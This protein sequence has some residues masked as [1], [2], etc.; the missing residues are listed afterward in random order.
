MPDLCMEALRQWCAEEAGVVSDQL[1]IQLNVFSRWMA[2]ALDPATAPATIAR[3]VHGLISRHP[4]L[5]GRRQLLADL[6]TNKSAGARDDGAAFG[7]LRYEEHGGHGH[8]DSIASMVGWLIGRNPTRTSAE[9]L[10]DNLARF[11]GRT[12]LDQL[13]PQVGRVRL[14]YGEGVRVIA[15][16]RV[17]PERSTGQHTPLLFH[18]VEYH[19]PLDQPAS[20]L[21]FV[22]FMTSDLVHVDDLA[23]EL[24]AIVADLRLAPPL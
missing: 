9:E 18:T 12:R 11:A 3:E 16:R 22:R 24:E 13:P 21:L 8:G 7:A 20:S 14:P 15:A 23:G 19:V 1:A 2:F 10:T 17:P 4:A 6:L 5:A